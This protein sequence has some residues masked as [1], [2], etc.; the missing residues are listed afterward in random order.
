MVNFIVAEF[1]ERALWVEVVVSY[2]V[3]CAAAS[4]VLHNGIYAGRAVVYVKIAETCPS[5]GGPWCHCK[6]KSCPLV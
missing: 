2:V 1:I 4:M 3:S 6:M 5:S